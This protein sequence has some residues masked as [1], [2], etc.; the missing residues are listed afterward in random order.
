M[1]GRKSVVEWM[2]G[3]KEECGGMDEWMEVSNDS[4]CWRDLLV[5]PVLFGF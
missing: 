1:D 5:T 3:W 2:S 4:G